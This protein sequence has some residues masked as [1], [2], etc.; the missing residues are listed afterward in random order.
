VIRPSV[1]FPPRARIAVYAEVKG[2]APILIADLA[3]TTESVLVAE[4]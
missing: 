4:R 2:E 3:R 1:A